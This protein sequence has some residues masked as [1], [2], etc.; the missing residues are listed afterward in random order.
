[1]PV[2]RGQRHDH[3]EREVGRE[4]GEGAEGRGLAA[5]ARRQGQSGGWSRD[6]RDQE[7]GEESWQKPGPEEEDRGRQGAP[8]RFVDEHREGHDPHPVAHLIDRVGGR[9]AAEQGSP[10]GRG[11]RRFTHCHPP[12][13]LNLC[14]SFPADAQVSDKLCYNFPVAFGSSSYPCTE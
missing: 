2:D 3:G 14:T 11:Y 4:E 5:I 7:R 12:L 13:I 8:G 6:P 1:G 9:E 10:E